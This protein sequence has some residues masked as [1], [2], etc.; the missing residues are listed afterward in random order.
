MVNVGCL[1][2]ADENVGQGAG[3]TSQEFT[4]GVRLQ[5]EMWE[6]S[7]P[8]HMCVIEWIAESEET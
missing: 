5:L 7:V 6:L 2:D 4:G 8:A 3:D 1:L